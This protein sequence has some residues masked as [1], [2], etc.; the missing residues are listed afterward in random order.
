MT[1][2]SY[3]CALD[4]WCQM[5]SDR[6]SV[7]PANRSEYWAFFDLSPPATLRPEL[8]AMVRTKY[9]DLALNWHPDKYDGS[10]ACFKN[11]QTAY[12]VE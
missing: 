1:H 7:R 6:F 3:A 2:Q 4:R 12:E 9:R 11:I 5:A 8:L 10:D